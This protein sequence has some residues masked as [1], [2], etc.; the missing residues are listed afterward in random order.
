M[1]RR[2]VLYCSK[3]VLLALKRAV[4]FS[5]LEEYELEKICIQLQQKP[6]NDYSL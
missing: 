4:T 6:H 5:F 2:E 1:R 3:A